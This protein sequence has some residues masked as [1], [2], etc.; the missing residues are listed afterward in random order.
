MRMSKKS[1]WAVFL[2]MTPG[3]DYWDN[4]VR[5][6]YAAAKKGE[7]YTKAEIPYGLEKKLGMTGRE[8]IN[9]LMDTIAN[10]PEQLD[11]ILRHKKNGISVDSLIYLEAIRRFDQVVERYHEMKNK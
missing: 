7:Y 11:D 8:Y 9:Q 3:Q 6:D 1:Y 5:P 10:Q 2:N 4:L